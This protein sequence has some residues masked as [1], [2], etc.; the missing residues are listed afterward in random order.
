M[1]IVALDVVEEKFGSHLLDVFV[2]L[3]HFSLE[4]DVKELIKVNVI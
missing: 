4:L 1:E 2:Q 3:D